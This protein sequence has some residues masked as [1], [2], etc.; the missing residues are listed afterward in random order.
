V[1]RLSPTTIAYPGVLPDSSNIGVSLPQ[2]THGCLRTRVHA[3][4][5]AEEMYM[6]VPR[7]VRRDLELDMM[8][9]GIRGCSEKSTSFQALIW[10]LELNEKIFSLDKQALNSRIWWPAVPL[11]LLSINDIQ[12]LSKIDIG[13]RFRGNYLLAAASTA[14]PDSLRLGYGILLE[15]DR[16]AREQ[17]A[18]HR[19]A[20]IHG[21]RCL[22]Q[23]DAVE[24]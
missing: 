16:S 14:N 2:A 10:A 15:S 6:M 3:A 22:R 20:G 8:S 11:L 1:Q 12:G 18:V 13:S 7:G 5:V 17:P 24:F 9:A 21:D 23:Y 19:C 4:S